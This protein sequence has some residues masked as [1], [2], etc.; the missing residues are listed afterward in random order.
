MEH[1]FTNLTEEQILTLNPDQFKDHINQLTE[2]K[3]VINKMAYAIVGRTIMDV[4]YGYELDHIGINPH[5]EYN[6]EGF[7]GNF[8]IYINNEDVYY[9]HEPVPRYSKQVKEITYHDLQA[10]IDDSLSQISSII[11]E[12]MS[13]DYDDL[14]KLKIKSQYFKLEKEIPT[15]EEKNINSSRY[16]I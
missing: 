8:M 6:D 16:K 10:K 11:D 7:T 15:K 4:I 9:E 3:G 2:A 13:F 1:T 5:Y 14:N 12:E